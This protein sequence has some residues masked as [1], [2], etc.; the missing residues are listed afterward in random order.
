LEYLAARKEGLPYFS[1]RYLVAGGAFIAALLSKP[2][3]VITPFVC[4]ILAIGIFN[5]PW[6]RVILEML[7][8]L[9]AS[10]VITII[11]AIV[12]PAHYGA[13][14]IPDWTRPLIATDALAF[15][16]Q[17]LFWPVGLCID[18][19]RNPP[20][21]WN[22]SDHPLFWTWVFPVTIGIVLFLK[23]KRWPC[24]A[25]AALVSLIALLPVLGLVRFNFQ[26]I[27]TVADHYFYF[28]MLGAAI[29]LAAFLQARGRSFPV[30]AIVAS[31]LTVL[32][33][34]CHA[35]TFMWMSES[36]A[37]NHVVEVSPISEVGHSHL[38]QQAMDSRNLRQAEAQARAIILMYPSDSRGYMDLGD[39]LAGTDRW[40]EAADAYQ[41]AIQLEPDI[42]VPYNNLASVYLD[43]G[44]PGR[45]IPLFRKALAITPNFIEA[46]AGLAKALKNA[47]KPE[48]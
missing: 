42:A 15:Y 18:Y 1:W 30:I 6:R 4:A 9:I 12:Q 39:T 5:F 31:V 17:K 19:S 45:A 14:R 44:D 13:L 3:A 43:H 8:A 32:A 11:A 25:T 26:S 36:V 33:V 22:S 38:W 41:H 27:S 48:E 10:L 35:Q 29:A 21:V 28:A 37:F 16:L 47:G 24:V 46:K 7:P 23:R 40:T 2:S 34:M 20:N